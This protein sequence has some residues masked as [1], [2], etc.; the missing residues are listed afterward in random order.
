MF[1]PEAY[2]HF[3]PGWGMV[4]MGTFIASVCGLMGI[5]YQY[6]PDKPSVPRTF[7]GGLVN[8]LGGPGALPVS[9]RINFS[10]KLL[11]MDS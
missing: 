5:V 3:S 11:T 4:L 1:S 7:P 8:E 9:G 10:T 2:T 6:Y